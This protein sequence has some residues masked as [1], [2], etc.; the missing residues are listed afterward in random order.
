MLILLTVLA[1][2]VRSGIHQEVPQYLWVT[3]A[4]PISITSPSIPH[5]TPLWTEL[6]SSH[7]TKKSDKVECGIF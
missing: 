7:T 1:N 3:S 6:T 4:A 5:L 2:F